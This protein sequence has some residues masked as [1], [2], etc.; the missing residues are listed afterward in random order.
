MSDAGPK[1]VHLVA[2]SGGHLELLAA[3][4]P[5]L[6][7][8]DLTWV[9]PD[10]DRAR[11]LEAAGD[12]LEPIP[13]YG[14][15]PFLLLRH[16]R[17]VVP[18]VA[19]EGPRMVV[20]AGAGPAVPFCLLARLLG[21]KIVFIETMARVTNSSISGSI[22][23]RIASR[24]IVQWPEM[25]DVYRGA[26]L[27]QPALLSDIRPRRA[28]VGDGTFVAVGTHVQPF[29]RLL[30]AVDRAVGS[31]LLPA[32]ATGQSGRARYEPTHVEVA[33]FMSPN[34]INDS[35][36][37]AR[38]VVCHAGSGIISSAL[39]AGRRPIV[40]PRLEAHG[41]HVDDHQVQIVEKLVDAGLVI[42]LTGELTEEH[43]AAADRPL[44]PAGP[45]GDA[46]GSPPIAA[47]LAAALLELEELDWLAPSRGWRRAV[48][49]KY[50]SR[51]AVDRA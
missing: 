11:T 40:M 12:R 1:Q 24:V 34:D 18:L 43:L 48:G 31:G 44:E 32:P 20:T 39:R 14:R 25:L 41:E 37:R 17:R 13:F 46:H 30:T 10:S 23:S 21:G 15:D 22:L 47:T 8:Y 4:A 42:R 19:S 49:R 9:T 27:C 29:D 7:D 33:P 26:L 35:M 45:G 6:A 3:V 28:I 50:L 16:L 38:Y 36:E 2:S 51:H 5:A